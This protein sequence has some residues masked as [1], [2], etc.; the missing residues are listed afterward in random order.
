VFA[1]VVTEL[2]AQLAQHFGI[3]NV[4]RSQH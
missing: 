4:L 3:A 1:G 2:L